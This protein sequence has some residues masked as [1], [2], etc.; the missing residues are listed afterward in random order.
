MA[1]HTPPKV[2]EN[3]AR[4]SNKEEKE[5]N[6]DQACIY[7]M[8]ICNSFTFNITLTVALDLGFFDTISRAGHGARLSASE[9]V[10]RVQTRNPRATSVVDRMLHLLA[11]YSLLTCKLRDQENGLVERVYGLTLAG[12]YFV[13]D[14]EN[15]LACGPYQSRGPQY[16]KDAVLEDI[17]PFEK[18]SG[19][20]L[21]EYMNKDPEFNYMFNKAMAEDS[22]RAMKRILETYKGFE[23]VKVLV[24]V[25]GGIEHVGGDMFQYIPTGDA[26]L[27][28][29][30]LHDFNEESC[31]K[32]LKNCHKALLENGKVIIVT[33]I[34]PEA[35]ENSV[36]AK[37]VAQLDISIMSNLPGKERTEQEFKAL[38]E[39]VGF[40]NF[41]V[42][43]GA[44]ANWI[45]ECTSKP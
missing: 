11:I 20:S 1:E 33:G 12:K 34:L 9:I 36:E 21:F 31:L 40:L 10:S 6:D 27:L 32:I 37:L 26:I 24:D 45:I 7:A 14:S 43:Y 38:A 3:N 15:G 42:V 39:A 18:A 44:Q 29:N 23:D 2:K 4:C 35:G 13:R 30:I 5:E 16:M 19:M 25:G 22:S 41:C 28:K 17:I 8:Q